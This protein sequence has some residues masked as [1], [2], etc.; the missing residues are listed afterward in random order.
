MAKTLSIVTNGNK[1]GLPVQN[2]GLKLSKIIAIDKIEEHE[3]FRELY[4]IDDDLLAR[5]AEDMKQNKFDA[6][7]PVHI[8]L[9]K[10]EDGTEHFYLIDGYTRIKAAKMANL[11]T[12]PYFEHSFTSFEEAHRYALHL[13]VDRRNLESSDLLKN[14]EI[15][16]GSDYIQN[17]KGNKNAAIGEMLGVSEKTVERAKFVEK[18][19]SEEQMEAIES[20]EATINSTYDEIKAEQK[21]EKADRQPSVQEDDSDFD[22]FDDIS[23]ALE[24]NSG[25]PAP[26]SIRERKEQ[27]TNR[28]SAEEELER[29][30]ERRRAYESGF[31]EGFVAASLFSIGK[32][33]KYDA[34]YVYDCVFCRQTVNFPFLTNLLRTIRTPQELA[35]IHN[36]RLKIKEMGMRDFNPHPLDVPATVET[37]N[38]EQALDF[39]ETENSADEKSDGLKDEEEPNKSEN[40]DTDSEIDIGDIEFEDEEK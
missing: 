40:D 2:A 15:L 16:M 6:S 22:S 21:K 38:G 29:M 14:I 18:N 1:G 9:C 31:T 35:E 19:A 28:L 5:I 39:G 8:W 33:L 7:Q 30:K 36:L 24:D 10:D 25:N 37:E 26:I 32:F 23:D 13:Q 34:A 11:P 20:G 17:M 4:S 12:V 27:H 3:K